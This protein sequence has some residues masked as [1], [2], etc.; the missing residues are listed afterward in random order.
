M[1]PQPGASDPT[2]SELVEAFRAGDE[3]AAAVLVRRHSPS[4]ARFLAGAGA[5]SS[6]VDD[7][8][9]ETLFR[10]F[11]RID[12]WRGEASFRSWLLTIGGNLLKDEHRKRKGRTVISIE[13]RDLPDQ[14]DPA[15]TVVADEL[16]SRIQF[17]LGKLP[18]LQR[19][20]FLLRAQQGAEYPDIAAALGTTPGAARVHF[21][22][23]VKALKGLVE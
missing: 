22:H 2:D 17:A 11:R 19:E 7:L 15:G 3:Q 4:L 23:A 18:R 9:Q 1:T 12:S 14:T 21:H 6:E 8:I 13:D 10:A 20:V 16:A 5:W